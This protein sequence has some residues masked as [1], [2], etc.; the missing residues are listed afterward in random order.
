[1]ADTVADLSEQGI[2]ALLRPYCATDK[3][4]DDGV[5]LRLR[6]DRAAVL[7]TDMLVDEVHFSN[8]TTS[9]EDVGWRAAAA[10]LSDLAAMGAVPLGLLVA[11]GLP[12]DAPVAWLEGFYRG[13][14]ACLQQHGGEILGGDVARSPVKT[15]SVT[16]CG[17]VRYRQQIERG[18]ARVGDAIVA[19]GPHGASRAGLELLLDPSAGPSLSAAEREAAIR[20]HQRPVPRFDVVPVLRE[21]AGGLAVAGMDSSDGL[22]DAVLQICRASSLGATLE[23]DRL[24]LPAGVAAWVGP[25][26]AVEWALYGGED[27]ELVLALPPEIAERVV[28]QLPGAVIVGSLRPGADVSLRLA[29]GSERLLSFAEGFQHF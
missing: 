25:E 12:G 22:A 9:A 13:M 27:F 16:A 21:L 6:R 11:L 24:P 23:R 14:A 2:L 19:T 18:V 20:A 4:G 29:D 17:E 7:S 1:M 15:V 28:R 3:V 10:N 8:R 5:L 26:K